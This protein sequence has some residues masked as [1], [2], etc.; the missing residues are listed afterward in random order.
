MKITSPAFK[1]NDT[2]PKKYTSDDANI[3]PPLHI[4]DVPSGAK[5]LALVV[6]DPD[7]PSG[8]FHHW[9]LFN[10]NPQTADIKE[11][12]V[13]VIAT[14]GSNDFGQLEYGGP[15]PP[16]GEHHYFFNAYALDTVLGLSRG[17]KSQ[18]LENEMKGHIL[19]QASLMGR[20]ARQ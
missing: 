20:Y 16:S 10:I 12:S 15:K 19:N 11:N 2:I 3:N 9:V 14:Q 8:V 17:A 1:E 7:A 6:E 18:D 4:E 13:P 5:S